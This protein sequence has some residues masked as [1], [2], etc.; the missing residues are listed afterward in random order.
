MR[1]LKLRNFWLGLL[2]IA[3]INVSIVLAVS[4]GETLV[5]LKEVNPRIIIDLKYA[6]DDN[7][8]KQKVYD[9][10]N[11]YVLTVLA[12]KLNEAQTILEQDGLG[13]KIFDGY[14]PISVQKKMWE[15]LPDS[16][17]VA[18]P[19][20]GG[21]IHNRGAAVDLTLVD[22]EGKELDM[23]TP[24]DSFNEKAYQFSKT[25]TPQQ[26]AN[27]MLLR[28]VMLE[29]GLESIRT[30]WWH[31]QIPGGKQYPIIDL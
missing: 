4:P 15:I 19:N 10:L 2:V 21:S 20:R 8:L 28:R 17:F 31:F 26:R 13:L 5:N 6:T 3:L 12:E 9:D 16:R 22:A 11:C 30:E 25:P 1:I 23:P 27:R 24:F 14:R 29:V 7:F 18:N